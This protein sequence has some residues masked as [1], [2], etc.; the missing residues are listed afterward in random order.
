MVQRR[1]GI[2]HVSIDGGRRLVVISTEIYRSA[3]S[4]DLAGKS[5]LETLTLGLV[6]RPR[7]W[8]LKSIRVRY[9]LL[10]RELQVSMPRHGALPF[11]AGTSARRA[12]L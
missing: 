9:I 7:Y 6:S 5:R 4:A 2:C 3:V 8:T 11:M 1:S 12:V 10:Y